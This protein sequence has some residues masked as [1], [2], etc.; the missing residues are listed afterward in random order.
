MHIRH[1][2]ESDLDAINR[3][4]EAAVMTWKLPERVKRLSVASH[5]YHPLDLQHMHIQVAEDQGRIMA[6][7]AVDDEP[8]EVAGKGRALLL[9]GL[10]VAPEYQG[11]GTGSV[12]F[13]VA[14]SRVNERAM[15]GLLVRAQKDALG[16]FRKQNMQTLPVS[17]QRKD[18]QNRFWLGR[19]S[20]SKP[21]EQ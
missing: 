5:F 8:V 6:V 11:Q 13:E 2:A 4:I 14:M 12:L 3:V 7:V 18:Y 15:D 17:D 9:H 21:T 1:A 20:H 19:K 10:Y 16:F